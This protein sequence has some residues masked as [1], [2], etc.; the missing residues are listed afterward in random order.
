MVF[1]IRM[2]IPEMLELW[3]RLYQKDRFIKSGTSRMKYTYKKGLSHNIC[4]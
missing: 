1:S 4:V 3:N 2:G